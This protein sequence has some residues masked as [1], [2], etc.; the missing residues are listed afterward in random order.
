[1]M[2]VN[3]SWVIDGKLA[4]MGQPP[5]HESVFETLDRKGVRAIVSLTEA[6][7][8]DEFIDPYDFDYLHLPIPDFSPP[9]LPQVEQ[10]VQYVKGCLAEDEPVVVHC[11]AGC[12]RTGTM[13]ACYFVSLGMTAEE[14]YQ[15]IV[16]LRPCSVETQSQ[17]RVIEHYEQYLANYPDFDSQSAET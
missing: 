5:S 1:M 4:G 16:S 15:K 9:T 6:P 8:P 11:T 7:L 13:L 10:F 3:F 2:L 14:A 12:G 17:K